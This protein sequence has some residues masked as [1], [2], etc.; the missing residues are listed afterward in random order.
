M[1]WGALNLM[2]FA[3][4]QT[5]WNLE[6]PCKNTGEVFRYPDDPRMEKTND[7]SEHHFSIRSEFHKN[8]FMR[9]W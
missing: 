2:N 9:S 6:K 8:R 3:F 7:V 5:A 1:M 4:V